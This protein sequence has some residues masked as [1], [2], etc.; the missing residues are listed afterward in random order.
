MWLPH[1]YCCCLVIALPVLLVV[2]VVVVVVVGVV[3]QALPALAVPPLCSPSPVPPCCS[4]HC[5][6]YCCLLPHEMGGWS[7]QWR[8]L[9]GC[10]HRSEV[11]GMSRKCEEVW[12]VTSV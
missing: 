12:G 2:V 11:V 5:C 7:G 8:Q 6:C 9:V 1:T 3:M 4:P 10:D